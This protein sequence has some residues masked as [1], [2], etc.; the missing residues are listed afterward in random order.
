LT[1]PFQPKFTIVTDTRPT[2]TVS[3]AINT[4]GAKLT[5]TK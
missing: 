2:P 3:R 1:T 5:L 4:S